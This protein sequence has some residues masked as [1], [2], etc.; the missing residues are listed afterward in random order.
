VCVCVCVCVCMYV[1]G[2]VCVC[3]CECVCVCVCVVVYVFVYV[4]VSVCVCE[5]ELIQDVYRLFY[6]RPKLLASPRDPKSRRRVRAVRSHHVSRLNRERR[7]AVL[8]VAKAPA[9]LPDH[10]RRSLPLVV[11]S[12]RRPLWWTTLPR[13][14]ICALSLCLIIPRDCMAASFCRMVLLFRLR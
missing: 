13:Y 14:V 7:A 12:L 11:P 5:Q 3:V 4:R 8:R 6:C 9:P 1:C 10:D 2:C